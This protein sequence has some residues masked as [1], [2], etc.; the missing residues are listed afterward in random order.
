[1]TEMPIT[2]TAKQCN[3]AYFK[4][5][6]DNQYDSCYYG[7]KIY[8]EPEAVI[9]RFVEYMA[10]DTAAN[11]HDTIIGTGVSG[12]LAAA[13]LAVTTGRMYAVLRKDGAH[14]HSSRRLEGQVGRRWIF[15]DDFVSGGG[16]RQR[17]R[18]FM[19]SKFGDDATYVGDWLYDS[20]H[21]PWLPAPKPE[22]KLEPKLRVVP[23]RV[24]ADTEAYRKAKRELERATMAVVKPRFSFIKE[25]GMVDLPSLT[26]PGPVIKFEKLPE[27]ELKPRGWCAPPVSSYYTTASEVSSLLTKFGRMQVR[28]ELS[29]PD[30]K[31]D[32]NL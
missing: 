5:R 19:T 11:D 20:T 7:K 25:D 18:D 3:D 30:K 6:G 15:V 23:D 21:G 16:T 4:R 13:L 8:Q 26:D 17:V 22:P 27:D 32:E 14:N 24:E 31:D 28:Y 10:H 1:M 12:S 9:N 29:E 2:F